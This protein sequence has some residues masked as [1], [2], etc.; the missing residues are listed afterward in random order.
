[1]ALS[2]L[3]PLGRAGGVLPSA[4]P[5]ALEVAMDRNKQE[6]E[7]AKGIQAIKAQE[8]AAAADNKQKEREAA[9]K[10]KT[11][12]A[13]GTLWF[14][15]TLEGQKAYSNLVNSRAKRYQDYEAGIGADPDMEGTDAY[16]AD[17]IE[18]QAWNQMNA[19]SE[20][21]RG[22]HAKV[23]QYIMENRDLYTDDALEKTDEEYAN[24]EYLKNGELPNTLV[25]L[26]DL[27]KAIENQ[28]G[29]IEAEVAAWANPASDG[30]IV[31]GSRTR[32]LPQSLKAQAEGMAAMDPNLSAKLGET[33]G[34]YTPEKQKAIKALAAANGIS[35]TA[36]VAL[37]LA[38]AKYGAVQWEAGRTQASDASAGR[39]DDIKTAS[40]FVR[41]IENVNEGTHQG[42]SRVLDAFPGLSENTT[43]ALLSNNPELAAVVENTSNGIVLKPGYELVKDFNRLV[44]GV[45]P[46]SKGGA[47]GAKGTPERPIKVQAAIRAKNGNITV[48]T[49]TDEDFKA[50]NLKSSPPIPKEDVFQKVVYPSLWNGGDYNPVSAAGMQRAMEKMG[51][52]VKT[53][54]MNQW[55][56]KFVYKDPEAKTPTTAPQKPATTFIP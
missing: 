2:S 20:Q 16:I 1:M 40:E 8:K 50:G 23:K 22:D 24:P 51:Y 13:D 15:H 10:R 49:G 9:D 26:I 36:A 38:T 21:L 12:L 54:T 55:N 18:L 33:M 42:F 34:N 32:V 3:D 27:N 31:S 28:F 11:A 7:L 14:A 44:V 30:G 29:A 43:K 25:A 17:Q 48:L 5:S 39:K 47:F 45:V 19:N 56:K 52:D 35:E 37:D 6:D 4:D 53:E 41:A 46:E